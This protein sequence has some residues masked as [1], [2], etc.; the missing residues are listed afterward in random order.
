MSKP[1]L[2]QE[3]NLVLIELSNRCNFSCPGCPNS[4]PVRSRAL[5]TMKP[6]EFE[7]VLGQIVDYRKEDCKKFRVALHGFGELT[8][9]PYLFDCLDLLEARG[10][11]RVGITTNGQELSSDKVDRLKLYRCLFR[12]RVSLNSC[13]KE[14]MEELNKGASFEEVLSNIKYLVR[15]KPKF[16]V[17]V[18]RFLCSLTK[19]EKKKDFRD[20]VGRGLY[21]ISEKA[22]HTYF[23]CATKSPGRLNIGKCDSGVVGSRLVVRWNGDMI[24]CCSDSTTS[25]VYANAFVD[26]IYSEKTIKERLRR[27]KLFQ[28][29]NLKEL[30]LCRGCFPNA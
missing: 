26:G 28:D 2:F 11:K 1:K 25:Q 19:R 30:P 7:N 15:S 24:G 14:T 20:L 23:G 8:I 22:L 27:A 4:N 6:K 21:K 18:Q 10:F 9:N 29:N 12:V 5:G 3:K 16:E 17:V 13:V